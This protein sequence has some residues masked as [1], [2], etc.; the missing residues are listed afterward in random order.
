M[1]KKTTTKPFY[2]S[3]NLD[4]LAALEAFSFRERWAYIAFKRLSD[5]TNGIVGEHKYQK[6]TYVK[7]A[8]SLCPPP[9][10]QGRGQGAIDDTQARDILLAFERAGLVA[11]IRHRPD[12][13]GLCFNL[14]MSPIGDKK[15][16]PTPPPSS[17][18]AGKIPENFPDK[19]PPQIAAKPEP[20]PLPARLHESLS[21][22]INKEININTE[23]ANL[24]TAEVAQCRA[25][26]AARPLE[27]IPHE[28]A[29]DAAALDAEEIERVLGANWSFPDARTEASRS[30]YAAWAKA[31]LSR[32]ELE[33][34]MELVQS[35]DD[36]A[37]STAALEAHL[38]PKVGGG[39]S[40]LIA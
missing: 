33:A 5:F 30:R 27:K 28:A 36:E 10:L 35:P 21:V 25:T 31:G 20:V 39:G 3:L 2:I 13:G 4:E 11:N 9:C 23:G 7:L 37:L 12:N 18:R 29:A 8:K 14:P 19:E 15:A 22:M 38:W 40:R 1:T 16:I 32:I 34:A 26:G 6:L 24:G 17:P